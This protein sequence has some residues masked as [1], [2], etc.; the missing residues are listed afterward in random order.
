ML[1]QEL[2]TIDRAKLEVHISC[3]NADIFIKD[4][5]LF[6]KSIKKRDFI[7]K[8]KF[9]ICYAIFYS[10]VIYFLL[11]NKKRLKIISLL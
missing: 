3:S 7:N 5:A 10:F 4:V 6:K 8:I 2:F 1:Y 9:Y 11:K